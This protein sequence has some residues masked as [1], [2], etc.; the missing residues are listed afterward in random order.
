M[1]PH[2]N[3]ASSPHRIRFGHRAIALAGLCLAACA[4][5]LAQSEFAPS[6]AFARANE[7]YRAGQFTDAAEAYRTI[8][9]SGLDSGPLYFNLGNALLKSG[10]KGEALWAFLRAQRLLPRDPDV[11]ANLDY[12]RSLLP[13]ALRDS[14]RPSV[15]VRV[16]T[17]NQQ[18]TTRELALAV[19]W[20]LWATA[21]F[22]VASMWLLRLR[23]LRRA[24]WACAALTALAVVVLMTQT[25]AIDA[26]ATAVVTQERVDVKFAPQEAATTHFTLSEGTLIRVLGQEFGWIQVRR[27]DGRTGWVPESAAQPL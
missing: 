9:A 8:L 14:V 4:S 11:R 6:A 27:A 19:A 16:L 22:G 25:V 13:M 26:V 23:G 18:M 15:A 2:L 1:P 3:M 5:A 7:R 24:G 12:V 17:L 21:A 10:R 20:L